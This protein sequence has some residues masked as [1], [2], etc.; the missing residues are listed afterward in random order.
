MKKSNFLC[1]GH[2]SNKHNILSIN[3]CLIS[4]L[5]C[6]ENILKPHAQD[7]QNFPVKGWSTASAWISAL[8]KTT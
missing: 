8:F 2:L 3:I 6:N 4:H 5:K 1:L 7:N